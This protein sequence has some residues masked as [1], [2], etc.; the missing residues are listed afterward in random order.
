MVLFFVQL[1]SNLQANPR[2]PDHGESISR[3]ALI[4]QSFSAA[5]STI[6]FF[7]KWTAANDA[8]QA[9][10]FPKVIH[11]SNGSFPSPCEHCCPEGNS[12]AKTFRRSPDIRQQTIMLKCYQRPVRPTPDWTS[13]I[14]QHAP[15]SLQNFCAREVLGWAGDAAF[16]WMIHNEA[17]SDPYGS[18]IHQFVIRNGWIRTN[19]RTSRD[20]FSQVA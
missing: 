9:S 11:H 7:I 10:G 16:A 4:E 14:N 18:S 3:S 1:D 5:F 17:P 20:F 15:R 2:T 13:S 6:F 19:A 8:A 12:A